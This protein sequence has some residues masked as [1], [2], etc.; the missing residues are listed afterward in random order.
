MNSS[1]GANRDVRR[2]GV[3]D[4]ETV[5]AI[6]RAHS[7][8]ARRHFFEKLLAAAKVR[9][10]DF[11]CI[12]IHR[13]D[14]LRGFAIARILRGEFGRENAVAVL[15][16]ISVEIQ[17]QERGIGHALMGELIETLRAMG[18]QSLQS[19]AEWTNH[20]LLRFFDTSGFMLAPRL[21]L[22][23]SVGEPLEEASEEI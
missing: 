1:S 22:E 21:S 3:D 7:G 4:V 23:R 6:D 18:V 10:A 13:D 19:L 14:A 16:A 8:R 5:I 15:D 9:P 2:L 17:S 12:G 20:D 11:V